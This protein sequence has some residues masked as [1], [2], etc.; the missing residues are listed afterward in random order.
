MPA[1]TGLIARGHRLLL[2]ALAV[3]FLLVAWNWDR[4]PRREPSAARLEEWDVADVADRLREAGLGLRL[5]ATREDGQVHNSAFLT[6]TDMDWAELNVLP[7]VPE[8]AGRWRGTLYVE[9]VWDRQQRDVRTDVWG[10][11]CLA[12]GPFLFFGD[13]DLLPRVHDALTTRPLN[14]TDTGGG[15]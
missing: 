10:D 5:V 15:P 6:A 3:A 12:V 1:V 9:R 13:R 7:K 4:A 14:S 8:Q 11:S 2:P